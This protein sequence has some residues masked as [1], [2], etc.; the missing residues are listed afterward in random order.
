LPTLIA[1]YLAS[2]NL[3]AFDALARSDERH[4]YAAWKFGYA[5]A[6]M[7]LLVVGRAMSIPVRG[8]DMPDEALVAT[9][10]DATSDEG[11]RLRELHCV[12]ALRDA[13][14]K[15]SLSPDGGAAPA[16]VAMLWGEA[17]V[18][19]AGFRRWLDVGAAVLSLHVLGRRAGPEAPEW[20]LAQHLLLNDPLLVPLGPEQYALLLPDSHLGGDIDRVRSMGEAHRPPRNAVDGG[21]IQAAARLLVRSTQPGT[22]RV[23]ALAADVSSSPATLEVPPGDFTYVL[24]TRD[25]LLVVGSATVARAGALEL[26]FDPKARSTRI[27][28]SGP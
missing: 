24:E 26:A 25:G 9:G 17:H 13:Q 10:A 12:L 11:Q 14:R 7:D 4:D 16:R 19:A 27:T 2:G 22:F 20:D 21:G 5:Q 6:A 23:G 1:S 18:G 8:C 28:I 15:R 3:D